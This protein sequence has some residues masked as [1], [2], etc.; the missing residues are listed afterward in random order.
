MKAYLDAIEEVIKKGPY[1]PTWES[2][3]KWRVPEWFQ[4]KKFGIFIH[5]GVYSVPAH[6]NEW[7][8]RN[9]YQQDQPEFQYHRDTYGSQKDFG[10][11][12]FIPLFTAEHFKPE[13]WAK[14]FH[15]A[16]A[17][18]VFP[19]AEHH[20]G[21]Q[22]YKSQISKW[23]AYKM[24]PK[25]DILGE[26]K[27]AF[28]KQGLTFCTSS[29]RAE[30]WFF[31]SGG[32]QFESD[33][34]E[35]L[36]RGDFYWPS[37]P[38]VNFEDLQS[39]PY[40]STEYLD[41]WLIRTCEIIDNYQ[42]A[43][44]YFDW[45]IQHEAFKPYL[46]KLAAYYYNCANEWGMKVAICYKHDALM[47]GTGIVEVERGAFSEAK[48]YAWQTDTAVARNSWCYT[49]S[50][51]YKSSKEII[52][53]LIDVVSKNGNLLLNIG[54]KADGTIPEGDK[55]IL[56]D[57][58]RWMKDNSEAIYGAKVWRKS[59]EGP[60]KDE[61][62]QFMDSK[63]TS[64]TREDFRFTVANGA[65]YVSAM[66]YPEDG[67]ILVKALAESKNQ[68]KPDFHGLIENVTVLGFDEKPGYQ[69]SEDGLHIHTKTVKSNFPVVFKITFR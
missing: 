68:N 57:I 60:T 39:Q 24:G 6:A 27:Q 12:D 20:D 25:R 64:Y 32:K 40:P 13:E 67:E 44:L 35:P 61:E 15:E 62:G 21:F 2:L 31:M 34:K 58:G 36:K 46:L 63:A 49:D 41:D 1:K 3:S 19:V 65:L 8:S 9:M 53:Q 14:L 42:P 11:K 29:H 45:W 51:E 56:Q 30:H 33:I 38:D 47:F 23:N 48:P 16:G 17:Q 5:W 69:V 10:Y 59:K 22:M 55:Q 26:L 43:I 4:E 37:M 50:L 52:W 18:Y 7:Y 54:P 66:E 28:E